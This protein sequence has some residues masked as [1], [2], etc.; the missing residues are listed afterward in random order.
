MGCGVH[1]LVDDRAHGLVA[2]KL[3]YMGRVP[4]LVWVHVVVQGPAAQI[5]STGR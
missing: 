1:Q 3:M 4:R 5:L 2:Y